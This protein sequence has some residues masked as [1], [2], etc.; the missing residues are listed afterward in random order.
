MINSMDGIVR[1][2]NPTCNKILTD[3]S[4]IEYSQELGLYFCNYDCAVDYYVDYM[5]SVPLDNI[6]DDK[7]DVHFVKGVLMDKE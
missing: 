1:C 5:R 4:E 2:S 6:I 3:K 7:E